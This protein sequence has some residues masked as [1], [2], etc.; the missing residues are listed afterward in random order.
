M[1]STLAASINEIIR[2]GQVLTNNNFPITLVK[3]VIKQA[4]EGAMRPKEQ[5][6]RAI[7]LF[8]RIQFTANYKN[9]EE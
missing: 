6:A 4:S 2:I 7:N 1:S 9:D 8:Y 5:A 3:K